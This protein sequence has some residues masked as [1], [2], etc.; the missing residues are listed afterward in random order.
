MTS[1][2]PKP[3]ELRKELGLL[4]LTASGVGIIIG[5]GIYVLIG[6]ATAE[7]GAPVWAA[8]LLAA[9]L[10]ALTGLS[11][12]ELATM[13]P[14]AA[15]EFEYSRHALP[16]WMAFLTGWLMIA[17]LVIASATVALGFGGY[18]GYFFDIPAR[19]GG[20]FLLAV[21][22]AIAAGGIRN[23]ARLTVALSG[24]Q[25][26][27][28]LFVIAAGVGQ[29]GDVDLVHG[30]ATAGIVSAAALVFFA[31]I[32]FDEVTTLAEET[33]NPGRT[34]PL[35]LLLA[36]AIST[37]LYM[38]VA[39]VAVS[40]L[41]AEALGASSTPLSDVVGAA[42]GRRLDDLIA[43]IALVSTTNTT[44]L[45]TTAASRVVYGMASVG[46]LLPAAGRLTPGRKVPL[47]AVIL[48]VVLSVTF[49][50][51]GD[52]ALIAS[53]TDFAVYAVFLSVNVSLIILRRTRP[54]IERPFRV[55]GAI[56]GWPIIPFL[57]LATTLLMLTQLKPEALAIGLAIS[58][59]GM[60]AGWLIVQRTGWV[61]RMK[62][63]ETAG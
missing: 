38:A 4:S 55:P 62:R 27:G 54:G 47:R 57:G 10:S 9:V 6:A 15:A 23:S 43:V 21:V 8:F 30:G 44:L 41:G 61:E 49:L 31:F 29:V 19:V 42:T 26:A 13:Y 63:E 17:G 11:Y 48:C 24:V 35:A 58:V 20:L 52:L 50:F 34:V 36:L 2:P 32:G 14:R 5:A 45:A 7:A 39:I 33:R 3:P 51:L 1:S 12:C 56:R 18:L 37:V 59:V 25:V 16:A 22:C 53:V 40:V 60:I 28:L 46:A